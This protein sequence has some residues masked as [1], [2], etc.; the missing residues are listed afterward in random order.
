MQ[1]L[2][3]SHAEKVMN[4]RAEFNLQEVV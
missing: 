2:E 1:A 3:E 4:M